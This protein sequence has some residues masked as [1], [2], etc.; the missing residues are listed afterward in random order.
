[1]ATLMTTPYLRFTFGESVM[2]AVP[3]TCFSHGRRKVP[4]PIAFAEDAVSL[5]K[6]N[7]LRNILFHFSIRE[8]CDVL[9]FP[10]L[11]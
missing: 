9:F 6:M 3:L 11:T 8:I 7:Q 2:F 4:L 5:P 1:M 10:M